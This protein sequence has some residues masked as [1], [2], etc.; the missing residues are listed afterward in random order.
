MLVPNSFTWRSF[1]SRVPPELRYFPRAISF[2]RNTW[3]RNIEHI[4]AT[5]RLHGGVIAH[6]VL[7]YLKNISKIPRRARC[8]SIQTRHV[9]FP[10]G[11]YTRIHVTIYQTLHMN[12]IM[13]AFTPTTYQYRYHLP[14]TLRLVT[15]YT[16]VTSTVY[17]HITVSCYVCRIV[18]VYHKLVTCTT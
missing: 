12:A 2:I 10:R 16:I 13:Y 1:Y 11:M 17:V 6:T 5:E 8:T 18:N 7:T 4:T 3:D 9:P 15:G 14:E